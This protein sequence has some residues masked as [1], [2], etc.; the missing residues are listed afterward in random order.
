MIRQDLEIR[1]VKRT[2]SFDPHISLII[3]QLAPSLVTQGS[4]PRATQ[5]VVHGPDASAVAGSLLEMGQAPPQT[6]R[7][8]IYQMPGGVQMPIKV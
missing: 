1:N 4:N 2:M 7:T 5:C 6:S 3:C 8:R